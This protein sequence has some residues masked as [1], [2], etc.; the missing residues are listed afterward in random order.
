MTGSYRRA[1]VLQEE[2]AGGAA[3]YARWRVL[4]GIAAARKA[5]S[6][7]VNV[8]HQYAGRIQR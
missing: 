2:M 8:V 4:P 6:G 1:S 3:A 5:G 7:S